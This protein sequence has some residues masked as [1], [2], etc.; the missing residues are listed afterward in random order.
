MTIPRPEHP[1]PQFFRESWESLNGPWAFEID[2]SLSGVARGLHKKEAKLLQT[3]LVPFCPESP[4]SGLAFTD[5]MAGVWYQR[6]V[7]LTREQL[8]GIVRLHF[9][10]VD[11]EAFV[12]ING[13]LAGHHIG[14]YTSFSVDIQDF[15]QEGEN[16][17]TLFARDDV[18]DPMVPR[19][20]QSEEYYS[21]DCDYTRTTGIWQSVW[22][23]YLPKAHL[24]SLRVYP[25]ITEPASV[26]L[27]AKIDGVPGEGM[28]GEGAACLT[29]R[30]LWDG[31]VV[32]EASCLVSGDTASLSIPLSERHLWE[33]GKGGLYDLELSLSFG[34]SID[35]VQSYFGLRTVSLSKKACLINERPVFQRLVLDQGF[36]PDGI[37]TAP[38]DE[39]LLA[40]ITRSMAMGFNGARLHEKVFEERFLYHA[41]R[42]G[43]LVWGEYPNWGLDHTNPQAIYSF[44]P[45]WLEEIE[46]D[47]NHPA[48]IGW[49]P[50]NETWDLH[51]QRQ[52]DPLLASVY[53]S[54]KAAD[55]TRP[56]IDV[57]G[58]YHVITD[59]FDLHDYT[60]DP[61]DFKAHFP[62]DGTF[63]D[64]LWDRQK[65]AYRGQPL[66]VSEYGGI[67]W[68]VEA[69]EA[70]RGD[71]SSS[72][73]A[74]DGKSAPVAAW[75]YGQAAQS[76]EEYI[77]RF[78]ALA[79][80]LLFNP[81]CMG[82]CYTQLTDVEQEKNG[83]YT[84]ERAPKV[85]PSI[86]HAILTQKAA[87]E[88]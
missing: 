80:A 25:M 32:G 67:G 10:A 68:R 34:D 2:H 56:C 61:G 84:Y 22:L 45:P 19:G 63:V 33:V 50:F 70:W 51:H 78:K 65:D 35:K 30:A 79:E 21:H 13:A 9:G 60:Q 64:R 46:R 18:R 38:S 57:S 20:K 58:G 85:D 81:D 24:E 72:G 47:F 31:R 69:S 11:H 29:V 66:F 54:T 28:P 43:Y 39:A 77:A 41:D 40:D 48:L 37:Y 55:P 71:D 7:R 59:I 27:T 52:Y 76:K 86:F 23:E 53:A 83:V 36:Y 44:L 87:V 8:S 26:F 15:A 75:S 62:G 82:L 1:R 16:T 49:C 3:I 42:L 12:Y 6:S 4:L 5:F 73:T 88:E 14:G 17:V 74:Q